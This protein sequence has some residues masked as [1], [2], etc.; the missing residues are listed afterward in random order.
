METKENIMDLKDIVSLTPKLKVFME[1]FRNS[2]NKGNFYLLEPLN[3]KVFFNV[4]Y[5]K[6]LF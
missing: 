4:H 5:Y 2:I 3:N 6:F 1:I